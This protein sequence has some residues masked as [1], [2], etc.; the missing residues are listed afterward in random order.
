MGKWLIALALT[1]CVAW[2]GLFPTQARADTPK[3]QGMSYAAWWPGLYDSPGSDRALANLEATGADWVALIVTW[4]QDTT[5]STTIYRADA[6]PTDE[7]VTHAIAQAHALGLKVMLKPHVDVLYEDAWRG[8]IGES[9]SEAQWQKWFASYRSFISYYALIASNLGVEQFC[10]GVELVATTHRAAEWRAVSAQVRG[11]YDG[12]ITYASNHSG[13]EVSITWWDAVDY[14]GIDAYYPLTDENDPSYET[15]LAAWE[16]LLPTFVGLAAQW[17]KPIL[18]TE[19]GY[20]SIDGANRWPWD[21]QRAGDLDLQEQADCYRALLEAVWDQPWFAGI[22]WWAWDADPF[23]GG[24]SDLDYTPYD[25]PA[26]ALLRAYYGAPAPAGERLHYLDEARS[27]DIYADSLAS[28]WQDD[29]WATSLDFA[30]SDQVYRGAHAIAVTLAP[31]EGIQ[32][33]HA[34]FDANPYHW[35]EF[36]VRG[37]SPQA[38]E[39][40]WLT[41][42]TDNGLLVRARVDYYRHIANGR[43]EPGIW[44]RVLIPLE[45]LG[46]EGQNLTGVVIQDRSGQG[47]TLWLD[48]IRLVGAKIGVALP[49]ILRSNAP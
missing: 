32:F 19:V 7:D 48:E 21:W 30:A 46:A 14:I 16:A 42:T 34:A 2:G 5:E 1:I 33:T 29:S 11:L 40:L 12:P 28:G 25:K 22:Y 44:K 27:F 43:I 26:E 41:L 6:T 47:A 10:I 9:F 38:N 35:I 39:Q 37:N 13:E 31:W 4:Y 3:Q 18:F 8:E 49:L 15:L 45:S 24:P 23:A 20:R 36:Y 17:D